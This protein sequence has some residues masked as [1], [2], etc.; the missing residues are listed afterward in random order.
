MF[1]C[2][3]IF[4]L[5]GALILVI[6]TPKNQ[7]EKRPEPAT[8]LIRY[9]LTV[10]N[11]TPRLIKD[12]QLIVYAPFSGN[13]NQVCRDIE[14]NRPF[15]KKNTETGNQLLYFQINNLPPFGVEQIQVTSHVTYPFLS[16]KVLAE[17]DFIGPEPYIESENEKIIALAKT[18]RSSS[19]FETVCNTFQWISSNIKDSGYR[20]E[21]QGALYT[22]EHKK[23]D[24]TELMY[25][26]IALCRANRIPARGVG[27]YICKTNCFLAPENYHNWAEFYAGDHWQIADCQKEILAENSSDYVA[28]HIFANADDDPLEGYRRF[29]AKGPGI[30]VKM[31]H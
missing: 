18:L 10:K 20:K 4:V 15:L 7:P 27:G 14:A 2:L 23:G 12:G 31:N 30:T 11:T 3:L 6:P 24:C 17:S 13:G 5:G 25:L 21:R 8:K 16:E 9:G 19:A 28:L 29:M 22:L 1:S 26:F